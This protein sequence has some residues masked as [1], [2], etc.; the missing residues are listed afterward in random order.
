MT[1]P[2]YVNRLPEPFYRTD[3]LPYRSVHCTTKTIDRTVCFYKLEHSRF[4]KTNLNNCSL[5][6]PIHINTYVYCKN[7]SW[8]KFI[9][10]VCYLT[11][12]KI[13]FRTYWWQFV[14]TI[15]KGSKIFLGTRETVVVR[16][17]T[18]DQVVRTVNCW[19][20]YERLWYNQDR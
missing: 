10:N 12:G 19:W 16:T 9:L 1:K 20:P 18:G 4:L 14:S 7:F 5:S 11:R 8:D 13:Y 3:T 2:V 17:E 6:N 15:C